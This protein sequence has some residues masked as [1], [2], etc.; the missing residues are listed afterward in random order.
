MESN[1]QGIQINPNPT[2]LSKPTV[3]LD[4]DDARSLIDCARRY[5]LGR[6]TYVV[7]EIV[8]LHEKM[9]DD[10]WDART[11]IVAMRDLHDYFEKRKGY[12][13]DMDCDYE[14][15]KNL[16]YYLLKIKKQN[17]LPSAG[18]EKCIV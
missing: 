14:Q 11:Y 6:A 10:F 13:T 16:W 15:W 1:M 17:K 5:A 4:Y 2:S 7:S 12:A 9:P 18:V 3:Y 8:G